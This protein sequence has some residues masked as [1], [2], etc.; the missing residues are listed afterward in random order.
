MASPST[1]SP[2]NA[3]FRAI[4]RDRRRVRQVDD[5]VNSSQDAGN[6]KDGHLAVMYPQG[7]TINITTTTN[8]AAQHVKINLT[9]EQ[10][11]RERG[12]D[13]DSMKHW[14]TPSTDCAHPP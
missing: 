4:R 14:L 3:A 10:M 13:Y 5:D 2:L 8:M 9:A 11:I 1:T 6:L 12:E 7:D